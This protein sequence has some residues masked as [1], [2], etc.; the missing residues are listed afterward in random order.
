MAHCLPS[1]HADVLK[2][3]KTE[4]QRERIKWFHAR[5]V[6]FRFG[7]VEQGLALARQCAHEDA[8]FLVS[9]FPGE[10]PTTQEDIEK[11]FFRGRG[12]ALFVLG[13]C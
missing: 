12:R 7:F 13:C 2:M 9:L 6:F 10:A 8:R 4:A 11:V 1:V 3:A 5:S